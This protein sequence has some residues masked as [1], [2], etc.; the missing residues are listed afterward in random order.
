MDINYA[1]RKMVGRGPLGVTDSYELDLRQKLLDF[2]EFLATVNLEQED[3]IR[4]LTIV[5]M[6]GENIVILGPPGAGKTQLVRTWAYNMGSTVFKAQIHPTTSPE[7]ILGTINIKELVDSSRVI[8]QTEGMMPDCEVAILDEVFKGSSMTLNAT[9]DLMAN[10]VYNQMG[11]EIPAKTRFVLGTSNEVPPEGSPAFDRFLARFF[12]K[13]LTP[14]AM[15]RIVQADRDLWSD[16]TPARFQGDPPDLDL[17]QVAGH[18][19]SRIRIP[20]MVFQKVLHIKAQL[21]QNNISTLSGNMRRLKYLFRWLKCAA[22]LDRDTRVQMRH[23][24]TITPMVWERLDSI[25]P[26][27]EIVRQAVDS[28]SAVV[29]N[30]S[31]HLETLETYYA[32]HSKIQASLVYLIDE[33][34]DEVDSAVVNSMTTRVLE[35]A[36][37]QQK[38]LSIFL[39]KV[40]NDLGETESVGVDPMEVHKL[41]R[42][43]RLGSDL[44]LSLGN[45]Y[46]KGHSMISKSDS[47]QS[48][49]SRALVMANSM[50]REDS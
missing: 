41:K 22:W 17:Y 40:S 26:A 10:R 1:G 23:L 35:P 36:T 19:A 37:Q 50:T 18:L 15:A 5:A 11:K 46:N 32:E 43:I 44:W 6:M 13:G 2:E 9:L 14:N 47:T 30:S 45:L 16:R 12:T 48:V 7:E 27:T 39:D 4:G 31:K 38:G 29:Q 42:I 24:R 49:M 3:I 25:E 8:Y 34:D 21:E 28:V 33:S 20:E